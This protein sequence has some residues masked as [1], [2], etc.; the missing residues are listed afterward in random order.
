M[1]HPL[2]FFLAA[3]VAAASAQGAQA[4]AGS[5]E[6]D[7][8]ARAGY[9]FLE[10][11]CDDFGGRLVGSR[12]NRRALE[13]LAQ[14]LSALG[15]KPEFQEFSMPGWER[16]NDSV[17][18]LKPFKRSLRVAALSYTNP[19]T[20]FSADV[21][22]MGN[23]A[24][25]DYAASG[26]A[27]KVGLLSAGTGLQTAEIAAIAKERGLRAILFI[28][29]EAGGQ[30]LTRTGSF[31][32]KPLPIPVYSITQE[33]GLWMGRLLARGE[34]VRVEVRTTSRC[35]TVETA[36]LVVRLAGRST[37]KVIVGGH[38]DSWDLGQGAIDN[39]LGVAQL[40]ALA[41]ALR[42]RPLARTVEIVWFNGEEMGLWGSRHAAKILGAD[43]VIA[44][45]NLDMVGVPIGIN[46]LGDDSLVPTLERFEAGRAVKLPKG[47][48][49]VNWM[50]SDHTAYQ[51]V[52]VRAVTFNAPID[53]DSVRYYHDFADTIDKLPESI[54]VKS[55]AV[56]GDAVV[57]LVN[58][59]ALAPFR[60]DAK[61]TEA[62]FTKFGIDQRMKATGLWPT[63]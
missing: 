50:G 57:A 26:V 60:R 35:V 53:R 13:R 51:L 45:V 28:N 43:P 19:H 5:S 56:I 15:L 27:G 33:E 36:N 41:H 23:G 7:A 38:F 16:R 32:G 14:E 3:L 10:R 47:V 22:A 42:N 4:S 29:R 54:V 18:M 44:M 2:I 59:P 62:L 11:L 12:Q 20:P 25:T 39:G 34:P 61:E 9:A 55:T 63:H 21:V 1:R 31:V 58:D 24:A 6:W 37:D 17:T 49:N 8:S 30:L 48:E 46:A 40:F 52:G